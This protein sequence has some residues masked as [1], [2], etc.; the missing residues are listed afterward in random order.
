M[1]TPVSLYVYVGVKLNA[2]SQFIFDS[3]NK[4]RESPRTYLDKTSFSAQ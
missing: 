3:P 1:Y 2:P 4:E